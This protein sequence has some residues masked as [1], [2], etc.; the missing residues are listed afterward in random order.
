M[1]CY[2][3]IKINLYDF[4]IAKYGKTWYELKFSATPESDTDVYYNI[5]S[6]INIVMDA[7][8]DKNLKWE[9]FYLANIKSSGLRGKFLLN[10]L[11]E[12]YLHSYSLRD[13]IIRLHKNCDD[14]MIFDKWLSHLIINFDLQTEN[15]IF[16]IY[17]EIVFTWNYYLNI[18]EVF[19]ELKF[20]F[21]E[22]VEKIMNKHIYNSLEYSV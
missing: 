3:N 13:F 15:I 11:K 20:M 14:C 5:L 12:F 22:D 16:T 8:L 18:Y 21:N 17:R 1:N 19:D 2:K 9:E 10:I 7:P 4:Y 6:K